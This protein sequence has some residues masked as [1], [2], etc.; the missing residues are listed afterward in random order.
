M[1]KKEYRP[2]ICQCGDEIS[3]IKTAKLLSKKKLYGKVV[4]VGGIKPKIKIQFDDGSHISCNA[5]VVLAQQAA[6]YLY[7]NV[8]VTGLANTCFSLEGSSI[9]DY[10]IESIDM[11]EPLSLLDLLRKLKPNI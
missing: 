4:E 5:T 9:T 8:K 10:S 2:I 7:K 1:S 11:F 3:Q 6:G